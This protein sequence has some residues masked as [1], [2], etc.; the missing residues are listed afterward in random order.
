[1]NT[2]NNRH[3]EGR[4]GRE[5]LVAPRFLHPRW[6]A[7]IFVAL[8]LPK[9]AACVAG[10]VAL[11]TGVMVTPEL[12]G[13]AEGNDGLPAW[14]LAGIPLTMIS[15]IYLLRAGRRLSAIRSNVR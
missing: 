2:V 12:C 7:A 8:L 6:W 9:C 15:L 4:A 1:M 14:E 13:V 11:V 5:Q 10:Y 3:G